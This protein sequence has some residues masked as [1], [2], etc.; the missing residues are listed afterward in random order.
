MIVFD[1]VEDEA[2]MTFS[3]GGTISAASTS[4]THVLN[5][6]GFTGTLAFDNLSTGIIRSAGGSPVYAAQ[7]A[8]TLAERALDFNNAGRITSAGD[9]AVHMTGFASSVSFINSGTIEVTNGANAV[10][11]EGDSGGI[12]ERDVYFENSGTIESSGAAA[13]S[14]TNIAS[15]ANS[16]SVFADF[17]NLEDGVMRAASN[18][19]SASGATSSHVKLTNQGSI[20]ADNGSYAVNLSGMKVTLD[21]SGTI[22]STGQTAIRVGPQSYLK[23][24]GSLS[25]GGSAPRAIELEGRGSIIELID[26]AVVVGTFFPM[27]TGSYTAEEKH[28]V[29]LTAVSNASYLYDFDPDYFV[30]SINGEA[31]DNASGFS[32]AMSNFDAMPLMHDHHGQHTRNIWREFSRFKGK[33]G[34]RGFGFSDSLDSAKV[35]TRDFK[36]TGDR[37]GFAQSLEQSIFGLFDAQVMLVSSNAS[38]EMDDSIFAFDQSYQGA[39]LGF[40]DVLSLGPFSLSAM[41][42]TG[43]GETT[44]NRLV[45][46]NTNASGTFNMRSSYDSTLLDIVYEALMDVT[47]YGNKR[48]LT[49][50]KPYRLNLEIGLGG[51]IHTE[52]ND[53]FKEQTHM[54]TNGTDFESNAVG[55][56]VKLELEARN[57][58]TRK[59]LTSFFEFE[60]MTSE[61]TDG[62]D[63]TFSA[64]GKAGN[65]S[66]NVEALSVNTVSLGVNYQV[67]TDI[68]VNFS[69]SSTARDNDS[70]ETSAKLAVKW[71]F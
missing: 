27:D 40:S 37:T 19:F 57:P 67:E 60:S 43:L 69:Y 35:T 20:I 32:P 22:S 42:L 13:V 9:D 48:R 6:T 45:L 21:T 54:T 34:L 71:V 53:G 16:N 8:G 41:V 65:H 66:A 64:S 24:A 44:M 36:L 3:N 70:D 17:R 7:N 2:E 11:I 39:G 12:D 29:K 18:V 14:F 55:G 56:R 61:I 15:S 33:A 68:D 23:I 30:F 59:L 47:V 49:R 10:V 52:A 46:T 26:G 58:F 1:S 63:Y 50:R 38:Y 62:T 51:S 5:F 4:A 25:A 28:Q 31:Q